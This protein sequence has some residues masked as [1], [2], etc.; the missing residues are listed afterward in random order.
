MPGL[1]ISP[2]EA[3]PPGRFSTRQLLREPPRARQRQLSIGR[4][5]SRDR[6]SAASPTEAPVV[7]RRKHTGP[8]R[9][10]LRMAPT[11]GIGKPRASLSHRSTWRG[12]LP[13]REKSIVDFRKPASAYRGAGPAGPSPGPDEAVARSPKTQPPHPAASEGPLR[14]AGLPLSLAGR[15][16]K[17]PA[18]L[19]WHQDRASIRASPNRSSGRTVTEDLTAP[20][21]NG[22]GAQRLHRSPLQSI[23]ASCQMMTFADRCTTAM[24]HSGEAITEGKEARSRS[25]PMSFPVLHAPQRSGDAEALQE[26][27]RHLR[28]CSCRIGRRDRLAPRTRTA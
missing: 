1:Q 25:V 16:V 10:E 4:I 7:R 11:Q 24:E 2:T 23:L 26:D 28:W 17:Q 6:H 9:S 27:I 12:Y 13:A 8:S 18:N 5:R 21:A 19:A 14:I 15:R 20:G 3:R 22:T